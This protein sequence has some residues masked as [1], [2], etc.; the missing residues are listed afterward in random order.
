[1]LELLPDEMK[2][3]KIHVPDSIKIEEIPVDT[4][5]A[6]WHADD[7][8]LICRPMGDAWLATHRSALLK[9]PSAAHLGNFNYLGN[10]VARD[11]DQVSV[12]EVIGQPFPAFVTEPG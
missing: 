7:G 10:P 3:L 8:W 5:E 1:M 12:A 4:L 9:V 6:G 11:W 2:V